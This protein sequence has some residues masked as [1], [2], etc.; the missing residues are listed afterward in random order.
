MLKSSGVYAVMQSEG[1]IPK[2]KKEA[3]QTKPLQG[4]GRGREEW[5]HDM[6]AVVAV[7]AGCDESC[8]E[9]HSQ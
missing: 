4:S 5:A 1:W 2:K 9:R 3:F 8:R 7:L 6:L